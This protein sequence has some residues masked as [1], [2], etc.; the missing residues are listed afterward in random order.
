M[1]R[2]Y[3]ILLLAL[4]SFSL[5]SPAFSAQAD[6]N[7]PACCRR[8]GKHRCSAPGG[9]AGHSGAGIKTDRKCPSYPVAFPAP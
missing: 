4:F 9:S 3:A 5:L 6:G 1:R 2:I 8:D 7:L